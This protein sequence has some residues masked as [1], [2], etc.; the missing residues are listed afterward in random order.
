MS[1]RFASYSP[2]CPYR[3]VRMCSR[4]VQS[5][6]SRGASRLV[7]EIHS[8]ATR[9]APDDRVVQ[10]TCSP[11]VGSARS[12]KCDRSREHPG[13]WRMRGANV[14][15]ALARGRT[16]RLRCA[17]NRFKNELIDSRRVMQL[18]RWG[19]RLRLVKNSRSRVSLG[20]PRDRRSIR[21]DACRVVKGDGLWWSFL[22]ERPSVRVG[23]Q[24]GSTGRCVISWI[25]KKQSS[26]HRD[27]HLGVDSR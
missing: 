3:P 9:P 23:V 2:V 24:W 4:I 26:E 21:I 8:F 17:T 16:A 11:H 18:R 15:S 19:A 22:G 14:R 6:R 13:A 5:A 27:C 25:T 10:Y 12:C 7:C 20:A 1:R